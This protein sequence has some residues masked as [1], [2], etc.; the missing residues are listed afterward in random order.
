MRAF[1]GKLR[2]ANRPSE[3]MGAGIEVAAGSMSLIVSDQ[4]VAA[5]PLHRVEIE[6]E[7]DG[8]HFVVDGEEFIFVTREASELAE[9]V[10]IL[11]RDAGGR[12]K[13]LRR[14]ETKP[15]PEKRD[16]KTSAKERRVRTPKPA[17]VRSSRTKARPTW[18][19]P[20]IDIRS[21][22]AQLGVAV[23]VLAVVLGIF[24]RPLLAFS[25]MA[26]GSLGL[27]FSSGAL[28][29]PIVATRLPA[30]LS[31]GKAIM[32]SVVLLLSGM[33]VLVI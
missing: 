29:D 8:F 3:T 15:A 6:V 10:G 5:W 19:M 17:N 24:A 25:F 4:A 30:D 9:A 14:T 32:V 12:T 31:P 2:L 13:T 11:D 26:V 7:S 20:R 22:T 16:R 21:R 1:Q 28:I 18:E 23:L 27:L 33:L